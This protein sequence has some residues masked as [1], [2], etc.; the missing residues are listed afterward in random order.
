[1]SKHYQNE[2]KKYTLDIQKNPNDYD[3]YIHR[4]FAYKMIHNYEKAIQDYR[5]AIKINPK[6][7]EAYEELANLFC[8]DIK[9]YEFAIEYYTKAIRAVN[10]EPEI[11]Q[12]DKKS[13]L[14]V[15][16]SS[17]GLCY[18]IIGQY[19][20]E[21]EDYSKCIKLDSYDH[22]MY[23]K[24]GSVYFEL[25][26]YNQAFNDFDKAVKVINAIRK[27]IFDKHG[28]ILPTLEYK[29]GRAHYARGFAYQKLGNM[30]S[31]QADFARAKELGYNANNN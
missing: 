20:K 17:R 8:E 28:D 21:I 27:E 11:I 22:D 29:L 10:D 9:Q 18:G 26:K 14:S 6:K 12:G 4:A 2:V 31:A 24:R 15:L 19:D 25:A 1:M 16:Y 3:A 5:R 23:I 30:T 7:H 13:S